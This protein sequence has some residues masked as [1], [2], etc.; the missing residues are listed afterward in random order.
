[1]TA[2]VLANQI[3][4]SNL[5]SYLRVFGAGGTEMANSGGSAA[6]MPA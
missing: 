6:R 4:L 1:M 5:T 2:N 3:G